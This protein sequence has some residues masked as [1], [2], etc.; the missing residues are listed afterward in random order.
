MTH[1]WFG[2]VP[3]LCRSVVDEEIVVV[4]SLQQLRH[5]QNYQSKLL[6][7]VYEIYVLL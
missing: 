5:F 2:S 4:I 7:Q 1:P 3:E 6:I